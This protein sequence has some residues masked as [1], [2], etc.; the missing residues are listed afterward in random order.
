MNVS[1]LEVR[2]VWPTRLGQRPQ[3][4]REGGKF[5]LLYWLAASYWL[6][7]VVLFPVTLFL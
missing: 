1:V 5:I 7:T 2:D 6:A 3:G 4:Q